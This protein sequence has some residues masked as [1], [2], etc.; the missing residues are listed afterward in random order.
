MK[1]YLF[2]ISSVLLF[3][4]CNEDSVSSNTYES[5]ADESHTFNLTAQTELIVQ[6][7]NGNISVTGSDTS[8]NMYC[9][10]TKKVIS[11]ISE[12][13]AQAHLSEI[14]ITIQENADN[15]KVE[16]DNPNDD[17][18]DYVIT[19]NI[20]LPHNFDQILTL[21]NGNISVE[22]ITKKIVA[23]L[24]NGIF[25]SNVTLQDTCFVEAAVGNGNLILTIPGNTNALLTASVGNGNIS[26]NGLNF[27]NQ[28]INNN[29]FSGILGNGIGRILLSLGN[30]N[31]T[32]SKL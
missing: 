12:S 14:D 7:N 13:D 16:V 27:Q 9:F 22:S 3:F 29:H 4:G 10:I 23:N 20:I 31:I 19:L 21:G 5:E 15:V 18:R 32:M 2:I 25:N 8:S 24:G 30:G 28:Q 17:D 11:K 1:K 26:N 6:N